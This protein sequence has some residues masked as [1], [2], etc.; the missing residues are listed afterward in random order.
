MLGSGI[1]RCPPPLV[2][3]W[4]GAALG[5]VAVAAPS[6]PSPQSAASPA[7]ATAPA[8][9][10]VRAA[11]FAHLEKQAGVKSALPAFPAQKL[12]AWMGSRQ[13]GVAK[14]AKARYALVFEH[15]LIA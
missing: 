11:L 5:G 14:G 2:L 12:M 6:S 1:K 7:K 10:A 8:S 13:A 3:A 15:L 9:E 4:F